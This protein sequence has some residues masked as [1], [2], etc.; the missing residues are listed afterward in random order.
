[1]VPSNFAI[2]VLEVCVRRK[3]EAS[4]AAALEPIGL[5]PGPKIYPTSLSIYSSSVFFN[6]SFLIN[7]KYPQRSTTSFAITRIPIHRLSLRDPNSWVRQH[8]SHRIA[9]RATLQPWLPPSRTSQS[10]SSEWVTWERCT[11]GGSAMQD[12]GKPPFFRAVGPS[13]NV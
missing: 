7:H 1:M 9:Q 6:L 11:P 10:A 4:L 8:N 12:G 5:A 2:E 3:C 13:H